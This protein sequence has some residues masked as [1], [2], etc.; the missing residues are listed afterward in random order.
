MQKALTMPSIF[1]I[2]IE[3]NFAL[4]KTLSNKT[5]LTNSLGSCY[6]A[7]NHKDISNL[8]NFSSVYFLSSVPVHNI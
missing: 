4:F 3:H 1:F 7:R 6:N 5:Y 2:G 8:C